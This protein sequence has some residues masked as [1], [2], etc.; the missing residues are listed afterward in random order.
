[1]WVP[2]SIRGGAELDPLASLRV[3]EEVSYGDPSTGWV[4]MA[5]SLA[6]G[7]G[8]AFIGD[9]AVEELFGGERLPV[10]AGQGTRP[11]N[12]TPQDGG[13]MLSGS[14]SFASGIKP[15]THWA[16]WRARA[17]RA[18]SCCQSAGRH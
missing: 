15:S 7:T 10:I 5:A 18:S 3:L 8:A 17:S 11:G 13:F 14:W 1:M 2:Q 6:I 16:W 12:A 9:A 4:L